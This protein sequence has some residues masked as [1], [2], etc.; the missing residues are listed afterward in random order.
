[1]DLIT[2]IPGSF[3]H[4]GIGMQEGSESQQVCI[5]AHRHQ[6]AYV[7]PP[8]GAHLRLRTHLTRICSSS[9]P[10][11]WHGEHGEEDWPLSQPVSDPAMHLHTSGFW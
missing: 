3:P 10:Q 1:M 7:Q 4:E 9:C 8:A 11:P 5:W 2:S 6:L